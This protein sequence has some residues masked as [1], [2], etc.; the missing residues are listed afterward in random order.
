MLK[1]FQSSSDSSIEVVY[2][3]TSDTAVT[4]MFMYN[5]NASDT[6]L[7]QIYLVP[8]VDTSSTGTKHIVL[9]YTL[10]PQET[11]V[12]DTEKLVL[13]NGD[14]IRTLSS[15]AGGSGVAINLSLVVL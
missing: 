5:P 13:S 14:T 10:D 15:S 3:A 4:T 1:N 2:T 6:M 11:F 12:F 9:N 7:V 8:V